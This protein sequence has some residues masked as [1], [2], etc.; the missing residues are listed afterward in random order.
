MTF[1]VRDTLGALRNR[2]ERLRVDGGGLLLSRMVPV[3]GGA[4]GS[5]TAGD[6]AAFPMTVKSV[7]MYSAAWVKRQG[8]MTST[9]NQVGGRGDAV[10]ASW[11]ILDVNC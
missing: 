4:R 5:G 2:F 11:V 8:R 6:T 9:S 10:A 7:V 1:Q 3:G